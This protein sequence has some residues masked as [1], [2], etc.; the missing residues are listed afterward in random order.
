MGNV[1]QFN[2]KMK[3]RAEHE[4]SVFD[5][6]APLAI[7]LMPVTKS[8]VEECGLASDTTWVWA[9]VRLRPGMPDVVIVGGPADSM[10]AAEDKARSAFRDL[11][12]KWAQQ[13][14]EKVV[15]S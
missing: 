12:D 1:V 11:E 8:V 3:S 7:R 14:A 10:T 13:R 4:A 15:R 2:V 9:L 6:S 5:A